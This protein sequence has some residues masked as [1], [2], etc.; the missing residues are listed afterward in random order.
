MV[1]MVDYFL[2]IDCKARWYWI[3]CRG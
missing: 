1:Y 3:I 2:A